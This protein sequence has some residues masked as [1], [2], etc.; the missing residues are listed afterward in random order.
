MIQ[1]RRTAGRTTR[2]VNGE[3]S[4]AVP[5]MRWQPSLT[6]TEDRHDSPL[7][8]WG[9]ALAWAVPIVVG[10]IAV[11]YIGRGVAGIEFRWL[12]GARTAADWMLWAL[13]APGIVALTRRFPLDKGGWLRG[14]GTHVLLGTVV[15]LLE[16]LLFTVIA[17]TVLTSPQQFPTFIQGFG[18]IVA[19]WFPYGLLV[20]WGIAVGAHAVFASRR[21]RARELEAAY[22]REELTRAQLDALRMQLQPHFMCNALN[23][24][25]VFVRDGRTDEAGRMVT[26]LGELF[27]RSLDSMDRQVVTLEEELEFVRSYLAIEE[28]RFA[29]RLR[30]SER[31]DPALLDAAV[32][33]MILQPLVENAMRHGIAA[34]RFAS[35]IEIS[36]RAI[37]GAIELSVRDDGPGPLAS[38]R[39]E[40]G[41]DGPLP[42]LVGA[43]DSNGHGLGLSN[44]ARRL[45]RL[46]GSSASVE[47]HRHPERGTIATLS[48]PLQ[49]LDAR[50]EAVAQ[51]VAG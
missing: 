10:A 3:P 39:F 43:D 21:Y 32:P 16:I 37:D 17:R 8:L 29:D 26:A 18:S 19:T 25:S 6:P 38:R 5:G 47:L 14:I 46:Y 40:S 11:A 35:S 24:V 50:A 2:Q 13:F 20:Y 12:W 23:T 51:A 22:L 34:D 28:M 9:I 48:F 41:K 1:I 33:N 45:E 44:A 30:V 31:I 27:T 7:R 49:S 15:A 42:D 36:A 4:G